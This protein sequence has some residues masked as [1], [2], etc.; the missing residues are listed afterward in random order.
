MLTAGIDDDDG[1]NNPPEACAA[2][3]GKFGDNA[4]TGV[5]GAVGQAPM[6]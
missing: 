6:W 2:V 4:V 5:I 1:R 3:G